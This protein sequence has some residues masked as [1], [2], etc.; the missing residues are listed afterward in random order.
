MTSTAPGTVKVISMAAI[1]ASM[2]AS[3]IFLAW[4]AFSRAPRHHAA[5][6]NPLEHFLFVH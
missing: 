3:A 5:I 2:Q 1:P 4:S 6:L